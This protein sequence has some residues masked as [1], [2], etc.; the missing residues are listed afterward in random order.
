M[1]RARLRNS[2]LKNKPVENKINCSLEGKVTT[3][4][5]FAEKECFTNLNEKNIVDKKKV[6]KTIKPL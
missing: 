2:C 6:W 5:S 3:V 1:N 4:I